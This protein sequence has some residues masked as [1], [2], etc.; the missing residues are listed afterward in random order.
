M[1]HPPVQS[2]EELLRREKE[3]RDYRRARRKLREAEG[4]F[5]L[6][7]FNPRTGAESPSATPPLL[8]GRI[9]PLQAPAAADWL[10]VV[11]RR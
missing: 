7:W 3:A 9:H 1:P 4:E 6:V 8:G 10:A 2:S 11:R 5:S